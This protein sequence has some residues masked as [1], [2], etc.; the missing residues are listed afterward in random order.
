MMMPTNSVWNYV[1]LEHTLLE[2]DS[3]SWM[4]TGNQIPDNRRTRPD[5]CNRHTLLG[6]LCRVVSSFRKCSGSK[7]QPQQQHQ[8][9]G[10]RE[11]RGKM[12]SLTCGSARESGVNI[13]SARAPRGQNRSAVLFDRFTWQSGQSA[14]KK[15]QRCI[16]YMWAC[17]CVRVSSCA[18]WSHVEERHAS[19]EPEFRPDTNKETAKKRRKQN[20]G[21]EWFEKL[22]THRKE[23]GSYLVLWSP[24]WASSPLWAG[25]FCIP[26]APPGRERDKTPGD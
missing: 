26:P 6:I 22:T 1:P 14:V 25:L 11:K 18:T 13:P 9:S 23:H 10:G 4:Q 8:E 19:D 17:V 3:R 21:L 12:F 16:T 15:Q 5:P 24:C 20:P 7:M 2:V